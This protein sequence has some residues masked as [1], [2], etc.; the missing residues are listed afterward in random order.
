MVGHEVRGERGNEARRLCVFVIIISGIYF[1]VF[2]AI[3]KDV[4]I[5]GS[6][7]S[8]NIQYR[9]TFVHLSNGKSN[10]YMDYT[11]GK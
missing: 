6:I 11:K 3:N 7:Q 4:Y 10:K 9:N 1:V 2:I 8:D 5:H